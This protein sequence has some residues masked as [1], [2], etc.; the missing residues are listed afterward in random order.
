[1][2]PELTSKHGNAERWLG[3]LGAGLLILLLPRPA[4]ID[5]NG[6][7]LVAIFAATMIGLILQRLPGGAMVFLGVCAVVLT[8]IA[9]IGTAVAGYSDPVVWL[10]LAAFF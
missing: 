2:S 3:V 10:V 9:P 1:M 4:T 6:W 7:L 5:A 8:G